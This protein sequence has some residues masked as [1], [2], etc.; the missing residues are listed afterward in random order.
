MT[1]AKQEVHNISGATCRGKTAAPRRVVTGRQRHV[2]GSISAG[3]RKQRGRRGKSEE[4]PRVC[5]WTRKRKRGDVARLIEFFVFIFF[6]FL[7][8]NNLRAPTLDR[9]QLFSD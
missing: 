7:E 6:Y 9:V 2:V 4:G 8:T 5:S 1:Y 3:N